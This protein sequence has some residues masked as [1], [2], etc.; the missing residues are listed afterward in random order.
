V[1]TSRRNA[2]PSRAEYAE[3][4]DIGLEDLA[5]HT[6]VQIQRG[7][8]PTQRNAGAERDA[9]SPILGNVA[10]SALAAS[11]SCTGAGHREID[12]ALVEKNQSVHQLLEPQCVE[13]GTRCLHALR[14]TLR[15]VQ[16]FF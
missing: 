13:L 16:S 6:A 4:L 14:V 11:R 7:D 8:Q 10:K 9:V 15:G 3:L 12:A 1:V 5:R 2:R